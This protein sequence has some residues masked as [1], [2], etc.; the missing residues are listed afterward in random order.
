MEPA[1]FPFREKMLIHADGFAAIV[2]V[3]VI[4]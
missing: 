1:L 3:I 2:I 4:W